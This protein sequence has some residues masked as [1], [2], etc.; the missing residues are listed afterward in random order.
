MT[1]NEHRK[2]AMHFCVFITNIYIAIN[3]FKIIHPLITR[4]PVKLTWG[5]LQ[6]HYYVSVAFDQGIINY[7]TK[8][9]KIH[10]YTIFSIQL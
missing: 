10:L 6:H 9:N 8:L 7:T 2:Y 1:R 5:Y 4:V 3:C